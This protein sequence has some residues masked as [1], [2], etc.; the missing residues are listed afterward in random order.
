MGEW[1]KENRNERDRRD[2]SKGGSGL[3]GRLLTNG[4][5]RGNRWGAGVFGYFRVLR[6]VTA[7]QR[8]QRRE[9]T[10]DR[11]PAGRTRS[12]LSRTGVPRLL[13]E[14]SGLAGAAGWPAAGRTAGGP[15]GSG[16]ASVPDEFV[17][18]R[19]PDRLGRCSRRPDLPACFP[20][21]GHAARGRRGAAGGPAQQRRPGGGPARRGA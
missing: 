2:V 14:T 13:G 7:A 19:E 21:A 18:G 10:R 16:G 15:G 3:A 5:V 20:A 8:A 11:H 6:G 4:S 12:T 9:K 1:R 17:R